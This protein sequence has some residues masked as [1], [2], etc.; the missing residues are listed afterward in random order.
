[1]AA[2]KRVLA[3]SAAIA[4]TGAA[5]VGLPAQPAS[6]H[7]TEIHFLDSVATVGA[8]HTGMRVCNLSSPGSAAVIVYRH[9]GSTVDRFF[10]PAYYGECESQVDPNGVARY[11]LCVDFGAEFRCSPASP[12]WK[13]P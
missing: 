3:A 12:G 4:S 2:T 11:R 10:G 7:E 9:P 8:G 13:T 6:A 5:V 1:M